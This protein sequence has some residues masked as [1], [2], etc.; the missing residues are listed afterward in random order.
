MGTVRK[1]MGG[2]KPWA[3]EEQMEFLTEKKPAYI[4]SRASK[5]PGDFWPPIYEEWFKK[6]LVMVAEGVIGDKQELLVS[7]IQEKKKVS[8]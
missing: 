8:R 5:V 2:R 6:L 3:T 7:G 4:T 1:N